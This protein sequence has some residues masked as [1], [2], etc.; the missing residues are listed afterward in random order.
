MTTISCL[1]M[2][3]LLSQGKHECP[4]KTQRK[5]YVIVKL[6]LDAKLNSDYKMFQQKN[7]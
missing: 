4:S 1:Y 6:Y 3:Y 7:T 5:Q 2:L